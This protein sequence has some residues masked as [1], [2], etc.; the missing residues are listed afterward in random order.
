MIYLRRLA[1]LRVFLLF[2]GSLADII[3]KKIFRLTIRGPMGRPPIPKRIRKRR[4]SGNRSITE[5][6]GNHSGA[7][8]DQLSF[9]TQA[10]DEAKSTSVSLKLPDDMKELLVELGKTRRKE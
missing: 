8:G 3:C 10:W 6:L 5:F 1:A 2:G 9:E 7:I 4:P